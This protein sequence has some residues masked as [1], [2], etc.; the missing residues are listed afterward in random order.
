MVFPNPV[1]PSEISIT[2]A[3]GFVGTHCSLSYVS[4]SSA[5]PKTYKPWAKFYPTDSNRNQ[6]FSVE[7]TEEDVGED[8][9]KDS[10]AKEWKIEFEKGSDFFGR[11][12]VYEF[13]VWGR[14]V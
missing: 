12:T 6:Q 3:G 4:P 13:E 9:V 2:F 14:N 10:G 7:P 1:V 11:I 8:G 5:G